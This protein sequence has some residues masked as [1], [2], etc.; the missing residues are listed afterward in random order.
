MQ[1]HVPSGAASETPLSVIMLPAGA[2]PILA[3]T[4][5]CAAPCVVNGA[6]LVMLRAGSFG[7]ALRR[8]GFT[9]AWSFCHLPSHAVLMLDIVLD[10]PSHTAAIRQAHRHVPAV[11]RPVAEWLSGLD[12]KDRQLVGSVLASRPLRVVLAEDS[13]NV[14]TV[15]GPDGTRRT[16]AM[17]EALG[18]A[19]LHLP[20]AAVAALQQEFEALVTY[21]G[22]SS[23]SHDR[24]ALA[25][26]FEVIRYLPLDQEPLLVP[27]C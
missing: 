16:S 10:A 19:V 23:P 3:T 13:Q 22:K 18:E 11:R 8:T 7:R 5:W 1:I 2:Y 9:M 12:G 20:E 17:P 6:P 4:S 26:N 25:T 21:A 15:F 14:S 24:F 27:D